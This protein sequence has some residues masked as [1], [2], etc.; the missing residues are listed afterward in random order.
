MG[1]I[2]HRTAPVS[3]FLNAALDWGNTVMVNLMKAYGLISWISSVC[4]ILRVSHVVLHLP[5]GMVYLVADGA[6]SL[7]Q[8]LALPNVIVQKLAAINERQTG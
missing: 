2:L 7:R 1:R 5:D 4:V 8:G 6:N 3:F